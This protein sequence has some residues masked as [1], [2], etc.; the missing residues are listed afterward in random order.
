M[1][2]GGMRQGRRL[3]PI[4]S[5]KICLVQRRVY[6]GSPSWAPQFLRQ[7]GAPPRP[8]HRQSRRL[9]C[10]IDRRAQQSEV[11]HFQGRPTPAL[12]A[13]RL[14]EPPSARLDGTPAL[15]RAYLQG[16]Q[17]ACAGAGSAQMCWP[18]CPVLSSPS[19]PPFVPPPASASLRT[20]AQWAHVPPSAPDP[21]FECLIKGGGATRA[22]VNPAGVQ[23][24]VDDP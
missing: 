15:C 14:A 19:S 4:T 24:R 16:R 12:G 2:S 23:A 18:A 1:S 17:L 21:T 7:D 3:T 20:A 10:R 8:R 22:D 6:G 11:Y 5:Q 13:K 9:A